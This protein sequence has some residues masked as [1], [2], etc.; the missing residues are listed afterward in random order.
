ML[1][2]YGVLTQ[3]QRRKAISQLQRAEKGR[4]QQELL[5]AVFAFSLKHVDGIEL[6]FSLQSQE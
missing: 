4:L 2:P 1:S 5:P 3:P 6:F